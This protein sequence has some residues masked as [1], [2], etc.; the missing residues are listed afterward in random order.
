MLMTDLSARVAADPKLA[1]TVL[2]AP[3]AVSEALKR[4][5]TKNY[6]KE[7]APLLARYEAHIKK[8]GFK[9]LYF[10]NHINA[11]HWSAGRIDFDWNWQVF[12]FKTSLKKNTIQ[13]DSRVGKS[14]SLKPL[15]QA[16]KRWVKTQFGGTDFTYQGTVC[17]K[18]LD[19]F[20]IHC[21]HACHRPV[22]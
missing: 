10:P 13:G 7:D 21:P 9:R 16:T 14:A 15:I 20:K 8:H 3:L 11:N 19:G 4:A 17:R 1:K 12:P 5:I 18:D 6:T 2:L 22:I